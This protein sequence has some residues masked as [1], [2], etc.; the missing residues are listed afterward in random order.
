MITDDG[1]CIPS[2][3]C[4]RPASQLDQTDFYAN[5]SLMIGEVKE[6]VWP[7]DKKS[8]S[9][10]FVEYT[11]E[12]AQGAMGDVPVPRIF[13]GCMAINFFGG[14]A[15]KEIATFRA[16]AKPQ[17]AYDGSGATGDQP[18]VGDGAKVLL[19][20]ADGYVTSPII[21]GGVR[22]IVD[23]KAKDDAEKGHH[24]EWVF[25]GSS[26][27]V[28][29]DGE[30]ELS[31]GGKTNADGSLHSDADK[32][33]S[34][35]KIFF[36]KKGNAIF[37]T[38]DNKE[39]IKLDHENNKVLIGEATENFLMAKTYRKEEQTKNDK[40]SGQLDKMAIDMQ[41]VCINLIISAAALSAAGPQLAPLAGTQISIAGGRLN[42]AAS[43]LM[44]VMNRI[45]I[46][47]S[48]IK[49]FEARGQSYLS[50]KNFS[51]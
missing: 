32:E 42:V 20:C 45:S 5:N 7:N 10:R 28:N 38:K 6:I 24:Y 22:H 9:K 41:Q 23:Y 36:D 18:G 8:Q 30:L 40:M 29:K 50:D 35:T 33:A 12:V 44:S 39:I 15:D 31:F 14:I 19:L 13:T 11:V 3:L 43:K 26:L 49:D 16:N 2:E 51:D 1:I 48:A 47:A 34:G 25:N 46:I 21:L 17:A 37:A 4:L 27:K